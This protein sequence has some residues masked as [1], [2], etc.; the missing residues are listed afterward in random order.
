MEGNRFIDC[1]NGLKCFT[2]RFNLLRVSKGEILSNSDVESLCLADYKV[3]LC[4]Q[5]YGQMTREYIPFQ[6][7]AQLSKEDLLFLEQSRLNTL[8]EPLITGYYYDVLSNAQGKKTSKYVDRIIE[9][10]LKVLSNPKKYNETDLSWILK[11]LIYNSKTYKHREEDVLDAI[12][13]VL[14]SDFVLMLKFRLMCTGGQ[15]PCAHY[16][17]H[18]HFL[19]YVR[20]Q[21]P[22]IC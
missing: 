15:S 19:M 13:K 8:D 5:N 6:D 18:A 22:D 16:T 10:Y 7:S 11:S 20:Y 21:V 17:P 1:L 14:S 3:L 4:G 9:N 2:D 12:D